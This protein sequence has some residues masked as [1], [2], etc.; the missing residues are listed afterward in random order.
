VSK[1][2][3]VML[4]HNAIARFMDQ[5]RESSNFLILVL[6]LVS[7]LTK[8]TPMVRGTKISDQSPTNYND[9]PA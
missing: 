8:P 3:E 5:H 6:D 2:I 9:C 7:K 4:K 1:I